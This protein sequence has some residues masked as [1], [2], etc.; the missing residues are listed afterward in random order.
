MAVDSEAVQEVEAE[1]VADSEVA[2]EALIEVHQRTLFQSL[3]MTKPSRAS[4]A[5]QSLRKRCH[6]S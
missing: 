4:C 6:S 2:E 3:H 5:A 1:V